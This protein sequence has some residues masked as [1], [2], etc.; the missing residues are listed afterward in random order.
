[1]KER[2]P[3][4]E[5]ITFGCQM[6]DHDSEVMAGMLES[7]G[8]EP[9]ASTGEADVILVNTCCVRE[10]AE[11]KIYGL[12][13]RLAHLKD[14]KDDLIIGIAGCMTQQPEVAR[15]IK[16]RFPQVDLILGTHNLHRLPELLL[17]VRKCRERVMEVWD[18]AG[19][20]VENL[21]IRRASRVKAWVNITYG[22]NNFCTYC[23]VP[24]VRGRERSRRPEDILNEIRRLVQEGYREVTLL[25]QNV[26]SYGKDLPEPTSFARLLTEMDQIPS[27]LR[28]RFTTSHPRDFTQE[29]IDTI[30]RCPHVCE[31]I[32]LPVQAGSNRILKLMNRGYDRDYY[33]DL[34]KRIRQAIP[35]VAITT[36]IMVG[37]PGETEEDFAQTMDL[38]ERVRFDGAFTFVYNP[39][40]GTPAA[41][42]PEQ[43][44]DEVKSER[45]QKLIERQNEITLAHN[46]ALVGRVEQILV[47][48]ESKTN[49]EMMSGRTRTNR[50]VIFPGSRD[51]AG[52]LVNVTVTGARLTHL[53]GKLAATV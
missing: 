22:C 51:L 36:D 52:Q 45:I 8:Y 4:Y 17:Q 48:G 46:Q 9:A 42:L 19:E 7:L 44:P 50:L 1:M 30:A 12:L 14:K 32:H 53:E 11:N 15:K 10:T 43:V 18:Q 13:G 37:F 39:R 33:L 3:T 41:R 16:N 31:H 20:I 29:L 28:I 2:I 49:P 27:L 35:G 21:P 40:P 38:V 23:I 47:E 5:V 26:N 34:V 25:G 24:Y 6:N